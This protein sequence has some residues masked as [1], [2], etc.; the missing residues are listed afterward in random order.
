VPLVFALTA[1]PAVLD[2]SCCYLLVLLLSSLSILHTKNL[3]ILREVVV[4]LG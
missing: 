4:S 1:F 3:E 2:T